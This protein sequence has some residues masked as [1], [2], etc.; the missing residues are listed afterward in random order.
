[1]SDIVDKPAK[2]RRTTRA[3]PD[4]VPGRPSLPKVDPEVRRWCELLELELS[5]WPQVTSRSMFGLDAFYRSAI[6]FAALPRTRAADSPSSMLIKLPGV[7][8]KRLRSGKGTGAGWVTFA[9][10]SETDLAEALRWLEQA[11][12]KAGQRRR[13]STPAPGKATKSR[14]K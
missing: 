1:L 7:H 6:I 13:S 4:A 2:P 12:V 5:G 10:E 3:K 9:M 11:Y 8:A 14:S